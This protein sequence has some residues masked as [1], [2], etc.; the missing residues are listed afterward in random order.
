MRGPSPFKQ[1]AVTRALKGA[2]AAGM[3]VDRVEIDANGKIVLFTAAAASAV[4]GGD[5]WS[6]VR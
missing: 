4:G 3:K 1:S 6:D 2:R 5:S